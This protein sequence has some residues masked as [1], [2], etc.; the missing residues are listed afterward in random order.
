MLS[1]NDGSD[2]PGGFP[3]AFRVLAG[4]D[5][6]ALPLPVDLDY[7]KALS[8]VLAGLHARIPDAGPRFIELRVADGVPIGQVR[9]EDRLL[10]FSARNGTAV[11][12][13]DVGFPRTPLTLRQDLKEWHRFGTR[14]NIPGIWF[15]LLSG[16]LLSMLIIT[17]IVMYVRLRQSRALL[18]RRQVFWLS[19]GLWRGFHRTV[20]LV[21]VLFLIPIVLSGTWMGLDTIWHNYGIPASRADTSRPLTDAEVHQM[22]AA[23]LAAF[24]QTEGNTPLKAIRIRV[25][26]GMKQG[27][28]I[29]GGS[30]TRQIVFN[31]DTGK[32]VS[33][34]EPGYPKS[35]FP[36][37]MQL[38]E[39]VKHFHTGMMFGL[40]ARF[41]SL[42]TGLSLVYLS[43]SGMVIYLQ[44][45]RKRRKEGRVA[46]FWR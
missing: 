29:T 20:S 18:G 42:M 30:S 16:L 2:G 25:Y 21:A 38:H 8:T 14:P 3:G 17:G 27:V 34:S 15:E 5:F 1:I 45:W 22:A 4:R 13:V 39:D 31:A 19:G 10:A 23:T 11:A 26:G 43:I 7:Q 46:P 41:V 37:G 33:L 28:T 9:I 24:R 12:A 32:P 44:M 36:F 40:P 6:H 35:A